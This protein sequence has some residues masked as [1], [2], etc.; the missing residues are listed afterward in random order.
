MTSPRGRNQIIDQNK[1]QSIVH[2]HV[3]PQNKG[4]LGDMLSMDSL[5]QS[6]DISDTSKHIQMEPIYTS[7]FEIPIQ[8][9]HSKSLKRKKSKRK[10]MNDDRWGFYNDKL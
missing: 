4:Y 5:D 8:D 3:S 6:K 7:L 10:T 9:R 1:T 2:R